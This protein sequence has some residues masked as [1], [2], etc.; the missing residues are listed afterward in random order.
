MSN[1]VL[2]QRGTI[3]KFEGDAIISFFGAP[4]DFEDHAARTCHA[5]I[6]M[7]LLEDELNKHFIEKNMTPTPLRTRFGI[8]TGPMVVGNMGTE[9]KMDYTMMGSAVNLAARLEGVNKKF[10]TWIL[11]SEQTREAA[12]K[13]DEIFTVRKLDRVRVVGINEPVRLFELINLKAKTPQNQTKGI[14]LFHEALDMFEDKNWKES[15]KYFEKAIESIPNDPPS[16]LYLK[17][18]T[19]LIE[20]SALS[21]MDDEGVFNL[22]EK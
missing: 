18:C 11:I 15:L 5:A 8:N 4:V 22:T 21:D 13:H 9:G 3:D 20:G 14:H 6:E 19:D 1:I 2:S 7:H 10:G 17:R 16:K 12:D